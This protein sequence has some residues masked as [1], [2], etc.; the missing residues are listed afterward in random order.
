LQASRFERGVGTYLD[1]LDALSNLLT[2]ETTLVG[3]A[4]DVALARLDV[5]RALGG[6]W[7]PTP[8]TTEVVLI[9][10]TTD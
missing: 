4:R 1:Y 6:G 8:P 5:H 3:A 2:V 10:E 9:S 7:T